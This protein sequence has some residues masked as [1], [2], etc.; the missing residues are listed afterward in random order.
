VVLQPVGD[1]KLREFSGRFVSEFT[2]L[3]SFGLKTKE[4]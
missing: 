1:L 4:I 3:A 2:L